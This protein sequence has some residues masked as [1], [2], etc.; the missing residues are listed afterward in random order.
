[1]FI[2]SMGFDI[3]VAFDA[4]HL[5][6]ASAFVS[7]LHRMRGALV[8]MNFDELAFFSEVLEVRVSEF[9]LTLP[10]SNAARSILN[11]MRAVVDG[12]S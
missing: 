5:N 12:L 6:D 7:V 11:E 3:P 8:V 2:D 9:G 10:L 4:L 1:M